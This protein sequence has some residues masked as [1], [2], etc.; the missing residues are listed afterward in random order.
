MASDD[1]EVLELHK[2]QVLVSTKG[3]YRVII[4]GEN[5]DSY[6]EL[7]TLEEALAFTQL[8]NRRARHGG[9]WAEIITYLEAYVRELLEFEDDL[10]EHRVACGELSNPSN[11]IHEAEAK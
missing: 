1:F 4:H 10:A 6:R 3:R 11:Q 8:F 2:G 5:D 9:P 7:Q